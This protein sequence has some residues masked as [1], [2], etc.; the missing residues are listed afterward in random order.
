MPKA[1]PLRVL[2][3]LEE[4]ELRR[5]R[6]ALAEL[7]E[8][9]RA[10]EAARAALR[11][12][13]PDEFDAARALPGGPAP[14]GAWLAAARSTEQRLASEA[15]QL[16]RERRGL[17]ARLREQHAAMRRLEIASERLAQREEAASAARERRAADELAVI[18]RARSKIPERG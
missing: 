10:A 2:A 13:V 8:R 11:T 6:L 16:E 5:T 18:R 17:E 7:G 3:K 15:A 4:L 14:L 1:T 12:A 9:E